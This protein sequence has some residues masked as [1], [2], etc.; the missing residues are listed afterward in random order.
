MKSDDS[1]HFFIFNYFCDSISWTTI[2]SFFH[3]SK[4]QRQEQGTVRRWR[5]PAREEQ[6]GGDQL[7]KNK[8]QGPAGEEKER[9]PGVGA[10]GS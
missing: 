7:E 5:G 2:L 9:G 10:G 1:M 8:M 4:N 6:G 3:K